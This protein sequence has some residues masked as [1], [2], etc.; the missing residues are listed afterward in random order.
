MD[1][2]DYRGRNFESAELAGA[3]L[4]PNLTRADLYMVFAYRADFTPAILKDTELLGANLIEVN[5]TGADLSGAKPGPS[6][7][8]SATRLQEQRW[9]TPT[10][11][12]RIS[13]APYDSHTRFR[14]IFLPEEHGLVAAKDGQ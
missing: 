11:L 4:A 5:L 13:P 2:N 3:D 12:K 14:R 10:L 8:G 1:E 6:N 7:I 9:L